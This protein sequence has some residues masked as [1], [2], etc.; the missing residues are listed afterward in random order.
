MKSKR[1]SHL[2]AA[3]WRVVGITLLT[4]LVAGSALAVPRPTIYG[5]LSATSIDGR[6]IFWDA[7]DVPYQIDRITLNVTAPCGDFSSVFNAGETPFFDIGKLEGELDG[8]YSFDL[9]VTPAIDPGVQE[10]LNSVR[11]TSKE[12]STL[13]A[14]WDKGLLP[15]GPFRQA[16]FFE[17]VRGLIQSQDE[18][19]EG[20]KSLSGEPG[21]ESRHAG[22]EIAGDAVQNVSAAQ[23]IAQ[24]LCVGFDCPASPTF[25]DTTILMMEN[26]TRIKFDDTSTA[27]S[28]PRNDW[29]IEANSRANGGGSYLAFNDCGQS[30]QGGCAD[31]PVFLVE[32]GARRNALYV[33]SSGEVGI[34]TANPVLELHAV[35]GDT[36]GLRLEQDGSSGFQPQTWD[37]AGNETSFFLRDVTS[38]STLPFRVRPGASSNSLVID[39]D[40]DVGV[41]V[42]SPQAPLHVVLGGTTFTPN[43]DTATLIQQTSPGEGVILSL[44]GDANS[45]IAFGDSASEFQ[46]R[47]VYE[48]SNDALRIFT[49]GSEQMRLEGDGDLCVGCTT[50]NFDFQVS[51][52][53][54]FSAINAGDSSFT[55]SSSRTLK[56]DLKP[57][58]IDNILDLVTKIDVYE[59]DFIQGPADRLGLMAEDFHQIFQRGS[60][61]TLNSQEIQMALWLAVQKLTQQN[62]ELVERLAILEET[63]K[64]QK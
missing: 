48:H 31:D 11:G 42:L 44:I 7:I 39:T 16:G 33:E 13:Q 37:L 40:S 46:G 61:A 30:S 5:T 10:E 51:N 29:E 64:A 21:L 45:Q 6:V 20:S 1:L 15:R 26:N 22:V 4:L 53:A 2:P 63:P 57:V 35:A 17:V 56:T 49:S 62:Q 54:T 50:T 32:A 59:Y 23:T 24:S 38:G 47:F 14:F 27:S 19:E 9:V 12:Q 25:D 58:R 52:G 43:P 3:S 36:P 34:G 55:T 28:F 41:G 18:T 8:T 60:D